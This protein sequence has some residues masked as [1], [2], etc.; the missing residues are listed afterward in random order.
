MKSFSFY[1]L[2][3]TA[4]S[5]ASEVITESDRFIDSKTGKYVRVCETI[6]DE[7][8]VKESCGKYWE[9][10]P[11][12]REELIKEVKDYKDLQEKAIVMIPIKNKKGDIKMVLGRVSF[13][14]ENGRID[15]MEYYS[16]RFGFSPGT[17]NWNIGYNGITKLDKTHQLLS[18][19]ELCAKED[20]EITYNYDDEKKFTIKKGERVILKGIFENGIAMISLNSISDN[21]LGYGLDNQLPISLS[22]VEACTDLKETA[23]INDSSRTSNKANNPGNEIIDQN[24]THQT[25]S[26]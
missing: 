9:K 12:K 2:F 7:L 19:K 15:V 24:S 23:L 11:R 3:I 18:H 20:T 5:F 17:T 6:N 1:L 16:K 14:Y 13:M 8:V 26:K 21:F 10:F 25:M 4:N 22:K